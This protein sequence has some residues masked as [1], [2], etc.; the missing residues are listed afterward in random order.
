MLAMISTS[1]R[2]RLRFPELGV[3]SRSLAV[4]GVV[5]ALGVPALA[6]WCDPALGADDA[7]PVRIDGRVE[8]DNHPDLFDWIVAVVQGGATMAAVVGLLLLRRQVRAAKDQIAAAEIQI[9]GAR[10]DANAQRSLAFQEQ[11]TGRDFRKVASLCLAY[12]DAEDAADCIQ[13]IRAAASSPYAECPC[14]PRSPRDASA[15][16][17]CVNDIEQV[18]GFFE[19]LGTAHN[20]G[21][22]EKEVLLRSFGSVPVQMFTTGWWH[23]SLVR[24]G[25][26]LPDTDYY[27]EFEGLV[28]WL[29]EQDEELLTMEPNPSVR[30]L[31]LPLDAERAEWGDWDICER[32]SKAMSDR[33]A[34]DRAARTTEVL[35]EIGCTAAPFPRIEGVEL[36]GRVIAVAPRLDM[37]VEAWR[38]E[39]DDADT[40]VRRLRGV[41]ADGIEAVISALT[42]RADA[43]RGQRERAVS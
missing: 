32:L 19:A 4:G 31:A 7:T 12:L 37:P 5:I 24:G 21:L 2:R 22:V 16:Q 18:F 43:V 30:L 3:R 35:V 26:M 39:L 40:I 9:S 27:S 15:P 23:I 36:V 29:R 33:L 1:V 41:D 10:D 6:A 38:G 28:R 20:A 17:P 34:A 25:R 8:T 11:Y 14:L 42:K 13:K